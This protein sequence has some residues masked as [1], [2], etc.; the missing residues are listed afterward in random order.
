MLMYSTILTEHIQWEGLQSLHTIAGKVN[1][2]LPS[3]IE[4][5]VP[6][7]QCSCGVV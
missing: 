2:V 4:S 6:E 3:V 7:L 5:Q 1:S